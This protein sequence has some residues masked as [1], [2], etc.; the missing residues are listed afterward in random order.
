MGIEAKL[1]RCAREIAAANPKRMSFAEFERGDHNPERDAWMTDILTRIA[2]N[3]EAMAQDLV[4]TGTA[5][6]VNGKRVSPSE[7]LKSLPCAPDAPPIKQEAKPAFKAGDRIRV[8]WPSAPDSR[9]F[10]VGTVIESRLSTVVV[11]LD[12]DDFER[13]YC[14]SQLELITPEQAAKPD[15]A[16]TQCGPDMPDL[17][18]GTYQLM[19]HKYPHAPWTPGAEYDL[20]RNVSGEARLA[21]HMYRKLP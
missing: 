2:I 7:Y 16:W 8:N 21:A 13:G 12:T 15:E 20:C 4:L 19:R 17:P 14:P 5:I 3:Y 11:L 1:A 6:S 10:H 9:H 18:G